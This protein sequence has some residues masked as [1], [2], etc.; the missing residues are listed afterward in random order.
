VKHVPPH[1]WS[2]ILTG[3]LDADEAAAMSAHADGC[4]R[5][6]RAR[7]RITAARTAF[8]DIRSEPSPEV[9]W[10]RVR[11]QVYWK[12]SQHR[13]ERVKMP[14]ASSFAVPLAS[15]GAV[16][17]LIAAV[18]SGS[19]PRGL[20]ERPELAS[21]TA[22]AQ[23]NLEVGVLTLVRGDV[24]VD[25]RAAV[26]SFERA[27]VATSEIRTGSGEVSVQFGDGSAFSVGPRS[28]LRLREFD[29][30]AIVLEIDG[31]LDV[32]VAPRAP[33]QRFIVMA[34]Q[35]TVEVRGTGFRVERF[36]DAVTVQCRHGRVAV[37]D[38]DGEV[39]VTGGEGVA[40]PTGSA[41]AGTPVHELDAAELAGL[42]STV[43]HRLAVWAAPDAVTALTA[44]LTVMTPADRNVRVDGA[45]VGRGP[46]TVRVVSGRHLVE[47]E[48]D[49][50]WV[51]A[52]WVDV[53]D[54]A[55]QV[56]A[57]EEIAAPPKVVDP[58]RPPRVDKT[59]AA[60]KNLRRQQL[61]KQLDDVRYC[62]RALHKQGID[63]T[64][65]ELELSVDANGAVRYANVVATDLPSTMSK[66]VR[67]AVAAM[68]FPAGPAAAWRE[69]IKP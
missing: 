34:G 14:R 1:R 18:A 24:T 26:E 54:G 40:V 33:G 32:D 65:V 44:P 30:H 61:G 19:V 20:R 64:Y 35:R 48:V 25:G 50:A 51:S 4:A 55:I 38:G 21:A 57:V 63:D 6:A 45:E 27:L 28:V 10:D 36:G 5:C 22:P 68:E 67:D 29:R 8:A 23:E 2:E 3:K 13:L 53:R 52:G 16:A 7:D 11:A 9:K 39:E 46:L 69:T 12:T 60:S 59:P 66:C 31:Q 49:G 42:A 58:P 62:A 47:T 41:V 37:K 15:L 43:P 56:A 17:V